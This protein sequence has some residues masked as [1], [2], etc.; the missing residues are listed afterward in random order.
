[1]HVNPLVTTLS[2]LLL[3]EIAGVVGAVVAVPVVA[4]LQIILREIL[5]NRRDQLRIARQPGPG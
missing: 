1:M 2:I 3:G 4:T 5:Q